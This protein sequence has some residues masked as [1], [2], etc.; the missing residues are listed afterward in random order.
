[1]VAED[2]SFAQ[3]LIEFS[4]RD[5]LSGKRLD[6][7]ENQPLKIPFLIIR[8]AKLWLRFARKCT[9]AKG[10]FLEPSKESPRV[11]EE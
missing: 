6:L 3:Y 1:M 7:E 2:I 8:K 4:C 9:E 11:T 5:E 10:F